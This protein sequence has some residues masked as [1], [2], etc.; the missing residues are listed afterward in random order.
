VPLEAL[1]LKINSNRNAIYKTVFDARRRLRAAL[2]ADGF[3]SSFE[4][5]SPADEAKTR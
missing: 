3:L 1:A 2:A 4:T 5:E